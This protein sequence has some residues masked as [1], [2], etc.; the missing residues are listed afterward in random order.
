MSAVPQTNGAAA[1]ALGVNPVELLAALI[2]AP[3][4]NPPGDERAVAGVITDA[5]NV[6][7]LP[8][9]L[10]IQRTLSISGLSKSGCSSRFHDTP[11]L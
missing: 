9:P 1:D 2:A 10:V 11:K 4:P 6:L 7:G 8:P 3:S 5:L